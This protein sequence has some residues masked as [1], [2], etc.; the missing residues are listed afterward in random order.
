MACGVMVVKDIQGR[1][2]SRLLRVLYNSVGSKLMCHR[3]ILPKGVRIT[4]DSERTMMNTLAGACA[5]LGSVNMRGMILPA[6]D[7]NR[8]IDQQIMNNSNIAAAHV[9]TYLP[10]M[11]VD[12]LGFDLDSYLT[13]PIMDDKYEKLN[14]NKVVKEHCSHL[15]PKQ[16]ADLHEILS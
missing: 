8:I 9:E 10:R 4:Q 15:N 12:E 6:F 7:K 1:A 3:H 14:I 13:A 16:Q 11:K 5:P 2:Y